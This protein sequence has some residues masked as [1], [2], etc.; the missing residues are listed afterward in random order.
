MVK[1][2]YHPTLEQIQLPGVLDALSDPIRLEI[3]LR[4]DAEGEAPCSALGDHGSKTNLSYHLARL[5]EAG[6]TQTRAEGP[7]R[8]ISLRR[9]DLDA[10]FP[11]LLETVLNSARAT[12]AAAAKPKARRKSAA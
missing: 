10:R 3:V 4:L 8:F 6:V 12:A 1:P 2:L 5:R 9:A 11:A 7:F